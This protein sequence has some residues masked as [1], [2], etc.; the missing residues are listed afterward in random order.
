[1]EHE[2][3]KITQ[4]M[5]ERYRDAHRQKLSRAELAGKSSLLGKTIELRGFLCG[6]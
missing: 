6:E 3:N 1:M 4:L 2:Y 5:P